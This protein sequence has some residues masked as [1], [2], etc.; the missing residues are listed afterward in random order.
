MQQD[1]ADSVKA[2]FKILVPLMV[3]QYGTAADNSISEAIA[4]STCQLS[5]NYKNVAAALKEA[6]AGLTATQTA[7]RQMTAK[8]NLLLLIAPDYTKAIQ[9]VMDVIEH[10]ST[11]A[12]T[13]AAHLLTKGPAAAAAAAYAAG[14]IDEFISIWRQAHGTSKSTNAC[15][16]PTTLENYANGFDAACTAP[17]YAQSIK[18]TRDELTKAKTAAPP[19]NAGLIGGNTDCG[20]SKS[21]LASYIGTPGTTTTVKWADGLLTLTK[22]SDMASADWK[23]DTAPN[24]TLINAKKALTELDTNIIQN[25]VHALTT[26]DTLET[27]IPE[28]EPEGEWLDAVTAIGDEQLTPAQAKTKIDNFFGKKRNDNISRP[29]T[30]MIRNLHFKTTKKSEATFKSFFELDDTDVAAL[31]AARLKDLNTKPSCPHKD[32]NNNNEDKNNQT[33]N[34]ITNPEE[35]KPD[36][37]CKYNSTSQACEKDPKPAVSKTNQE[38]GGADGKTNTN[39][40]GSNSFVIHKAPLWL[41]FLLF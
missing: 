17:D 32:S 16:K 14:R 34:K 40:T 3:V 41:A 10:S 39:T 36:V 28:G 29:F 4:T 31:T 37:G 19:A 35:C 9:I 5:T 33:C 13:K 8:L 11:K 6:A 22:G 15:I 1:Q 12:E 27:A 38:T 24:P 23:T 7:N 21:T 18:T 26:I 20:L 25:Q 2:I 30:L